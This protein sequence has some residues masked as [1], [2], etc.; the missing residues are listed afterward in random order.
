MYALKNPKTNK[1]FQG[2]TLGGD[3]I[4]SDRPAVLFS[5]KEHTTPLYIPDITEIPGYRAV[6]VQ[7][8]EKPETYPKYTSDWIFDNE[9]SIQTDAA[10]LSGYEEGQ[11]IYQE[12]IK[13]KIDL[14]DPFYIRF[15]K[16]VEAISTSFIEGMLDPMIEEE[17]KLTI[18]YNFT[19]ISN[20]PRIA[21]KILKVLNTK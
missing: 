6:K 7:S 5:N 12:Q 21:E 17:G 3:I 20:H 8:K 4:E 14:T 16:N 11:R 10:A 19:V 9:V 1:Y 18:L 2:Y 15:P 13:D